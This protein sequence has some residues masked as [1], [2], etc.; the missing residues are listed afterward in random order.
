MQRRGG[1]TGGEA[2]ITKPYFVGRHGDRAP[3]A[4]KTARTERERQ[5]HPQ[6]GTAPNRPTAPP[7]GDAR[8]PTPSFYFCARGDAWQAVWRAVFNKWAARRHAP[9]TLAIMAAGGPR[10]A[11]G[12]RTATKGTAHQTR[13]TAE[14]EQSAAKGVKPRAPFSR[15]AYTLGGV[16]GENGG[17]RLPKS[18]SP[19]CRYTGCS[20][21]A[22]TH[23]AILD[24]AIRTV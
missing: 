14:K 17:S 7:H 13:P 23:P 10:A 22:R 20:F 18:A 24:R 9:A 5:P 12:Q 11:R 4:P 6:R 19:A 8:A 15:D 21:P 2:T 16:I 1:G 3:A